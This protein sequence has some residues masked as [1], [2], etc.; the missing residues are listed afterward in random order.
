M[1]ES[2]NSGLRGITQVNQAILKRAKIISSLVSVLNTT[3]SSFDFAGLR[4]LV[5]PIVERIAEYQGVSPALL[6]VIQ[7]SY[8]DDLRG[9][10]D[11]LQARAI[12]LGGRPNVKEAFVEMG[13]LIDLAAGLA[14]KVLF[15]PIVI[16]PAKALA[17]DPLEAFSGFFL[18]QLRQHDFDQGAADAYAAMKA[19]GDPDFAL[20][21]NAPAPPAD[22]ALSAGEQAQYDRAEKLFN[23]RVG[24]VADTMAAE[25]AGHLPGANLPIFGKLT[26]DT[27]GEIVK[28]L[29]EIFLGRAER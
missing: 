3:A 7:G 10:P 16:G 8:I 17:G 14:D 9:L 2:Q 21:P 12:A 5:R 22:V 23:D 26:R 29:A 24:V 13:L 20:D 18:Q 19:I 27:I 6:Q 28:Y 11:E 1:D 4:N 15:R 25:L